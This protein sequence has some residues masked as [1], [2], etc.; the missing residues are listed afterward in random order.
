MTLD[1]RP[2]IP[3]SC[4]AAALMVFLVA[5]VEGPACVKTSARIPSQA[6]LGVRDSETSEPRLVSPSTFRPGMTIHDATAALGRLGTPFHVECAVR[7]DASLDNN[8]EVVPVSLGPG[9]S[10]FGPISR[11]SLLFVAGRLFW[12]DLDIEGS[13]LDA[14][15]EQLPGQATKNRFPMRCERLD[16][17]GGWV[18]LNG[19]WTHHRITM[20]FHR[21]ALYGT[22]PDSQA[23]QAESAYEDEMAEALGDFYES[24]A[25]FLALP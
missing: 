23:I 18:C 2:V 16:Y 10:P 17:P 13:I 20:A 19:G 3:V 12:V 6:L 11:G 22:I 25:K 24:G 9:P 14:R 7:A 8:I 5:W 21:A 4:I 15:Y 1:L